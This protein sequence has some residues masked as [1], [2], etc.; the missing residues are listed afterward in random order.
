MDEEHAS[1]VMFDVYA[2]AIVIG[3][4]G[5]KSKGGEEIPFTVSNCIDLFKESEEIWLQVY[6]NAQNLSNFRT[7]EVEESGNE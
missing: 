6:S 5:F 4:K 7:L 2:K 1:E 3:W